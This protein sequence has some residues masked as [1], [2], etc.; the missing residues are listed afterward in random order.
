[1][2]LNG[3]G[4]RKA[5]PSLFDKPP[6]F[7]LEAALCGIHDKELAALLEFRVAEGVILA[8]IVVVRVFTG[9]LIGMNPFRCCAGTESESDETHYQRAPTHESSRLELVVEGR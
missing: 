5:G 1:L 9:R 2:G 8:L 4:R 7:S 3:E 6:A